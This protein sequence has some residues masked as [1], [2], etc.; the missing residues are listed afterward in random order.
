MSKITIILEDQ[1]NG[2]FT[3]STDYGDAWNPASHAHQHGLLLV[4]HLAGLAERQAD[5]AFSGIPEDLAREMDAP[6]LP[7]TAGTDAAVA[8][9]A[10]A[11]DQV[12]AVEPNMLP[13]LNG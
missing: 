1:P 2:L 11:L 12:R 4:E 13:R 9:M 5:S 7:D 3:C 8:N 6:I 10:T